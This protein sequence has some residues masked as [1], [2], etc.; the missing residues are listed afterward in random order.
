MKSSAIVKIFA[1][2]LGLLSVTVMAQSPTWT[3][4]GNLTT[5]RYHHTATLLANGKVLVMGGYRRC[6]FTAGCTTLGSAEL[7][8]PSSGTW[9]ATGS[10]RTPRSASI[11]V[12]LQNGKVLIAGGGETP[13][14][15]DIYDPA[16]G[17]WSPTGNLNTGRYDAT[18]TLLPNGKVLIAGGATVNGN[19]VTI[20]N[21]A[22]LYDP[23]TGA[24][25]STGRMNNP[26][27]FHSATLL[28][29]G[30]VLVAGGESDLAVSNV[31]RSAE[32]YDPDTGTWSL[33]GTMNAARQ[34][35][36]ATLLRS[37][38]VLVASGLA[39][40]TT[41]LNTAELYDPVGGTWSVTGNLSQYRETATLLPNGKV[42][43]TGGDGGSL[44]TEMYDPATGMW[45]A[46]ASLTTKRNTHTV[47]FLAN[48][49]LLAVGG[50]ADG[51][52]GL[53][54]AELFDVVALGGV[55]VTVSGA[56]YTPEVA[57]ESIASAFGVNLASGTASASSQPL[58]TL[59]SGTSVKVKDSLGT[60]RDA[61]LFYVSPLQIN[62]LIP[63][64]TATGAATVTV[65]SNGIQL[66]TGTL[67]V[68]TLAPGLFAANANGQGIAAADVLRIKADNS[69]TYESVVQFDSAQNKFVPALIDLGAATESVF[70]E[71]YGTGIRARS[72]LSTVS[73]TIGGIPAQVFYAGAQGQ[74]VGVDQ[75]N[76][77]LPRSLAGRGEVTLMLTADGKVANLVTVGIR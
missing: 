66:A 61:P 4:T 19:S 51:E 41:A 12:R 17:T 75:V 67:Q 50:T 3:T 62:Y 40:S 30:K 9:S 13:N 57:S 46:S 36:T 47:T 43:A 15:A 22:E 56:S 73:A 70:V 59:L 33:T 26:R 60:E 25:S 76:V 16:T 65:L 54:S 38:K 10:V 5:G 52:N 58:P 28:P 6:S 63:A 35:H 18:G 7:Y 8:D 37:N 44:T 45:S 72:D 71:L 55:A 48:N 2:L 14:L 1:L 27:L 42:L 21:T 11:A 68:A 29:N 49:K 64:G 23:A 74:F 77:L 34:I 31:A 39:N 53:N 20:V 69:R 32:L 24:W